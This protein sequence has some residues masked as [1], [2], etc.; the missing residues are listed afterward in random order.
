MSYSAV[1]WLLCNLLSI[2]IL[3]FYSMMEMA[4]VSFNRVRLQYYVSKGYTRAIWLNDLLDHP[5]RLFG[6]TLI[7][8]NIALVVGSECSREFYSAIGLSPDISP[9][10]QVILVV[11]FG[12]LAPM[13]AARRYAEHVA[14]LGIPLIYASARL[15]APLLWVI[16]WISQSVMAL[17]G[18]R[19][20]ENIYLLSEEELQKIFEEKEDESFVDGS[21]DFS[22]VTANI[23]GLRDKNIHQIM[24]PL[25]KSK[26]LPSNATVEQLEA[27]IR[28]NDVPYVPIY[29]HELSNIIGIVYPRDLLRAPSTHRI[30]DYTQ[31]PWFVAENEKIMPVLKQFRSNNENM[32]IILNKRGKAVGFIQLTDILETIFGKNASF[33]PSKKLMLIEKTFSGDTTVGEFRGQYGIVLDPDDALSLSDLFAKHL[34]RRPEKGDVIYLSSLELIAK[35]VSLRDVK[36]V[37]ISSL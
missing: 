34:D 30:R 23:F 22:A 37:T 6:T 18:G 35:E 16:K 19:G 1:I 11:I 8:V 10:T 29:H 4:C 20:T 14:L 28:H 9:I 32:A 33:N 21:A 15:M 25:H 12:E 13:F 27:F 3:A 31:P 2:V 36:T 17:L 24:E 5:S 7:G 26:T